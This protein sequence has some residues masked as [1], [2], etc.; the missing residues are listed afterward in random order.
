MGLSWRTAIVTFWPRFEKRLAKYPLM[1]A[2]ESRTDARKCVSG[3]LVIGA[4]SLGFLKN[5]A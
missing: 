2:C 3:F 1:A 5:H 4:W